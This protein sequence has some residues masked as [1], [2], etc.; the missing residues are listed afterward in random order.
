MPKNHHIENIIKLAPTA[1]L[2][3]LENAQKS[4][5]RKCYKVGTKSNASPFGKCPKNHHIE[6]IIKLASK[7]RLNPLENAQKSSYRKY[8]KVGTKSN[9]SQFG[10]CPKIIISKILYRWH[11]KQG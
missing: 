2:T 8:Y 6:N 1:R 10:K 4:S 7:A 3:P 9:A 11:Q 5:Y